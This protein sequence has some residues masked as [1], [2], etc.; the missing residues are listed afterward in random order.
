MANDKYLSKLISCLFSK[1]HVTFV[2]VNRF[3]LPGLRVQTALQIVQ[4]ADCWP[5]PSSDL[6]M[7]KMLQW[8]LKTPASACDP[9]SVKAI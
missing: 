6:K 7:I 8:N 1:S 3:Y 9:Q 5:S 4:V 2:A